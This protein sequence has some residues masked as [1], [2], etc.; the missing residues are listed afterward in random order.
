MLYIGPNK[1]YSLFQEHLI[2]GIVE[3]WIIS[4]LCIGANKKYS[5]F[6]KHFVSGIVETFHMHIKFYIFMQVRT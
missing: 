6:Q 3:I 1:I 2:L 4:M 5:C